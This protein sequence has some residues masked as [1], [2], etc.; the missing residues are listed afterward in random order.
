MP[1]KFFKGLSKSNRDMILKNAESITSQRILAKGPFAEKTVEFDKNH[2]MWAGEHFED[3][4]STEDTQERVVVNHC[5][6]NVETAYAILKDIKLTARVYPRYDEYPIMEKVPVTDELGQPVIGEDGNPETQLKIVKMVNVKER[7]VMLTKILDAV[8]RESEFNEVIDEATHDGCE[9][10]TGLTKVYYDPNGRGE[11]SGLI[12]ASRIPIKNGVPADHGIK[13]MKDQPFFIAITCM[14]WSKI[15]RMY[16]LNDE[17][18]NALLGKT[19]NAQEL[20]TNMEDPSEYIRTTS[21]VDKQNTIEYGAGSDLIP[22]KQLYIKHREVFKQ[23]NDSNNYDNGLKKLGADLDEIMVTFCDGVLLD[24][25]KFY[26]HGQIPVVVMHDY[27][28]PGNFYGLGEVAVAAPLNHQINYMESLIL[29]NIRTMGSGKTFMEED[30]EIDTLTTEPGQVVTVKK[31]ALVAG[32]IQHHAGTVVSPNM[33]QFVIAKERELEAVSGITNSSASGMPPGQGVESGKAIQQLIQA[34][35]QRMRPKISNKAK[36]IK[37]FYKQVLFLV[38]EY[39]D[40]RIFQLA[41]PDKVADFIHFKKEV[42]ENDGWYTVEIEGAEQLPLGRGEFIGLLMQLMNTPIEQEGKIPEREVFSAMGLPR[43]GELADSIEK[44][45]E[46]LQK[47]K[48]DMANAQATAGARMS[49]QNNQALLGSE[50]PAQTQKG[51]TNI[52]L[53]V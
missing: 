26:G 49:A 1:S 14:P 7:A 41:G 44:R 48:A 28:Y 27:D 3:G 33:F 53:G 31:G 38:I 9:Y 47:Q 21:S 11:D 39:Y 40:D 15:I 43:G 5:F 19:S 50:N 22:V 18:Q 13:Y 16:D 45:R 10:G 35:S 36:Y 51:L 46:D 52:G 30:I 23:Y 25:D 32:K 24:V 20:H 6:K 37:E 29:A 4:E 17:Q 34:A 12:R 8:T 2:K 42:E